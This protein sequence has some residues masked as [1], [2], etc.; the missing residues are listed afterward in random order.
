MSALEPLP[1]PATRIWLVREEA[2]WI[3][4]VVDAFGVYWTCLQVKEDELKVPDPARRVGEILLL[5]GKSVTEIKAF[6]IHFQSATDLACHILGED[7]CKEQLMSLA[8]G[9][10]ADVRKVACSYLGLQFQTPCPAAGGPLGARGTR[11]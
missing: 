10:N 11:D 5:P 2:K 1:E 9:D 3:G 8:R 4:P 7:A 6:V